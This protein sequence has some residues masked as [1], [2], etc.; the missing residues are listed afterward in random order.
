LTNYFL[1]FYKDA[2]KENGDKYEPSSF[3]RRSY[4]STYLKMKSFLLPSGPCHKKKEPC[5]EWFGNKPNA[6]RE[7]T[8]EEQQKLFETGQFGDHDP[9]V[10]QRTLRWCLSLDFG[11]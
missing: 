4:R 1:K 3:L 9:L 6:T 10:L 7:L 2:R 11:F 8:K 5:S